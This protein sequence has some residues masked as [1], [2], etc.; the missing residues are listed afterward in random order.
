MRIAILTELYA[1]SVGGQ[2]L[3][4]AGLA[5][6]LK[7][8][9]HSVD[10]YAIGHEEDVAAD[11]V[12][13]GIPVHRAPIMAN[14]KKP[15]WAWAKRNWGAIFRYAWHVRQVAKREDYDFY[16]LNQWPLL[17][18][19]ALPA[20][21]RRKAMLHWCEIRTGRFYRA[22]QKYLPKVVGFNA[23]ISDT[24]GQT[25]TAAAGRPVLTLP[26]GI[27]TDAYRQEPREKRGDILALGRIAAH[28][29][30]SMLI[31]SFELIKQ[32]GYEGKLRIAGG[33]P[34]LENVRA[35]AAASA[36][37][38]DIELLGLIDDD[39]KIDL[40]SRSEILAMPSMREGFPRVVAEAM[41]S[42][43]PVVTADYPENGTKDVVATYGVGTVTGQG[44]TAFAAGIMATLGNWETLSNMGLKQ[45]PALDWAGIATAFE[46]YIRVL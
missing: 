39:S 43:L 22:I 27:A 7:A 29:N 38:G 5:Q 40:L 31:E 4:F 41:A 23:A 26:S 30:L 35:R 12:V 8:R 37:A 33:G 42:G 3:F 24:V 15:R 44:A 28:K 10:V 45:A 18:A 9:G 14:Y 17:H 6:T 2:E 32:Q 19:L 1:P 16:L 13:D 11:E 46:T 34:D 21:A 36:H 20:K 25:I